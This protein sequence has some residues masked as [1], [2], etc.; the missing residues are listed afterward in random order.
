MQSECTVVTLHEELG[1]C[2]DTEERHRDDCGT[3]VGCGVDCGV[4]VNYVDLPSERP[5]SETLKTRIDLLI[6]DGNANESS[7][8]CS[9][10]DRLL[11]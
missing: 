10:H 8:E 1:E 11:T 6:T 4:L 9:E 5:M 7:F 3:S 2:K